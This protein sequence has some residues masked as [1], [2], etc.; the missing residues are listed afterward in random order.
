MYP[1]LLSEF[2]SQN[3]FFWLSSCT[4][5]SPSKS[6][7]P[8]TTD[9]L[10]YFHHLWIPEYSVLLKQVRITPGQGYRRNPPPEKGLN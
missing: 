3:A 8:P 10:Q 4:C 1:P 9:I 6:C 5:C 2:L 7:V